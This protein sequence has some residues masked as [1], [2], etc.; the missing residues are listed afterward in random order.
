MFK[1][2]W[3]DHNDPYSSFCLKT[4]LLGLSDKSANS[5][6]VISCMILN[7]G[8]SLYPKLAVG[9]LSPSWFSLNNF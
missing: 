4:R 1:K 3:S 8:I 5:F 6:T 7:F 9:I 2:S